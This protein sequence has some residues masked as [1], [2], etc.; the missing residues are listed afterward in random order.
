[1]T[2][3]SEKVYT[4]MRTQRKTELTSKSITE[5]FHQMKTLHLLRNKMKMIFG[6]QLQFP[7]KALTLLMIYSEKFSRQIPAECI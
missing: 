7:K 5:E 3:N 6:R 2:F 1:M 4:L